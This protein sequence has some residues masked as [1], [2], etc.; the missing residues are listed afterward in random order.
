M[1]KLSINSLL[2]SL[3][4]ACLPLV[5]HADTSAKSDTLRMPSKPFSASCSSGNFTGE[6]KGHYFDYG[7]SKSVYVKQY[8]ITK[9]NG[10]SGGNKA[11]VN[12]TIANYMG[13]GSKTFKSPDSMK[14]DG[15]WHDLNV[16][17][18]APWASTQV[19]VEFIFDKSGSDPRCDARANL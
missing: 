2:L 17:Y 16:S 13:S 9:R 7:S 1:R 3:S 6:Y 4:L 19:L 8:K 10:Q 18:H 12:T 5:S 14:Q 15:N 11:N